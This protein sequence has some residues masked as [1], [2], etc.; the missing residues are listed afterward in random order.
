MSKH[1]AIEGKKKW[2]RLKM[3]HTL[4]IIFLITLVAVLLTWIIPAGEYV[5]TQNEEGITVVDPN[6]FHYIENQGVNPIDIASY[7]IAGFKGAASLICFT[8]IC[9]GA[10]DV[11][12]TSEAMQ[13]LVGKI[14]KKL[15]KR[16]A[17][18]I[19]VLTTMFALICTTQSIETFIGFAPVMVMIML[20]FGFDSICAAAILIIGGG[21]GFSTGTLNPNTTAISQKIAELPLYSGIGYRFVCMA[22]LLVVSNIYLIKYARKIRSTPTLSPMYDLDRM[23]PEISVDM[24]AFGDMTPRKWLVVATLAGTLALIVFGSIKMGWGMD[25]ISSC[26]IWM[27]IVAGF[28]AGLK[29]SE[30]GKCMVNGAKRVVSIALIIGSARAISGILADGAVLDTVVFAMSRVLLVLPSG[31]RGIA[32]YIANIIINLFLTSG[33]GQ[34][35]VVMPIFIPMADM[36]GITRQ[37]TILAFNFGDGFCNYI[38]PYSTT[39]MGIIGNCGVP[40]EKWMK[41]IGK[42]FLLWVLFGSILILISQLIGYGPM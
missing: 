22:V 33:S 28:C 16:E 19:P 4:V 21:I 10:F 7:M 25:N 3:P 8:L 11:I 30:I 17:I 39:T 14:A 42:L 31:L 18:F 9:G 34:A 36:V 26:F 24:D 38:L 15:A 27:A 12:V 29:P 32:M 23:R 35:A 1:Q 13:S 2:E 6:S 41:F 5:R 40:Y 20:A 37:T